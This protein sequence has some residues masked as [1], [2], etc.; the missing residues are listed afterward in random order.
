MSFFVYTP[1][2]ANAYGVPFLNI[3]TKIMLE[4]AKLKVLP[5]KLIGGEGS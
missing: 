2:I 5:Y 3:A 1:F 4:E